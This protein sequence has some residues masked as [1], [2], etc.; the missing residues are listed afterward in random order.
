MKPF[1]GFFFDL[2]VVFEPLPRGVLKTEETNV[3]PASEKWIP[4]PKELEKLQNV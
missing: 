3:L 1:G 4:I 2:V